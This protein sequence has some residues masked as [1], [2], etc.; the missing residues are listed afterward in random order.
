MD[1]LLS[2]LGAAR[3]HRK[4]NAWWDDQRPAPT[5]ALAA[6]TW[7]LALV[8]IALSA[9]VQS[10][11]PHLH[12][13]ITALTPADQ[14]RVLVAADQLGQ[15]MGSRRHDL[16]D[17]LRLH[18]ITPSGVVAL[19]L[20]P[21]AFDATKDWLAPLVAAG[22]PELLGLGSYVA[23]LALTVVRRTGRAAPVAVLAGTRGTLPT[24]TVVPTAVTTNAQ[25]RDILLEP[26]SWP[27]EVV[28]LSSDRLAARI[29]RQPSIVELARN[30]N[31][32]PR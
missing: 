11:V 8:S 1:E 3:K 32:F 24:G 2:W 15:R 14:G 25:A 9:P 13:T 31:W 19:L 28:R 18:A 20:H 22:L 29:A 17:A 23:D 16:A 6:G 21:L 7:S 12:E 27:A 30:D 5:D 4:D 26:G 10:H